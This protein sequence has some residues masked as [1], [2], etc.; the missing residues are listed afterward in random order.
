MNAVGTVELV[1][2]GANPLLGEVRTS[3]VIEEPRNV[4]AGLVAL[5]VVG[6]QACESVNLLA[7][8][9]DLGLGGCE[10]VVQA[11]VELVLAHFLDEFLGHVRNIESVLHGIAFLEASPHLHGVE[12]RDEIAIFETRVHVSGLF[13]ED[14]FPSASHP[15]QFL[16]VLRLAEALCE[17]SR[18]VGREGILEGVGAGEVEVFAAL[19]KVLVRSI[20]EFHEV[21]GVVLTCSGRAMIAVHLVLQ[22]SLVGEVKVEVADAALIGR[23]DHEGQLVRAYSGNVFRV[24]QTIGKPA[25][26]LVFL[27][28]RGNEF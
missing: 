17:H 3:T 7:T 23:V 25:A 12:I 10:D 19:A 13:V 16:Q 22:T 21:G 11:L 14:A 5:I 28:R 20:P 4:Q 9:E 2:N 6:T 18:S 27:K 15:H 1:A 24:G 8:R 26:I